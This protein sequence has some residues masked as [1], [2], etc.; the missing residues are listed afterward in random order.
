[1]EIKVTEE[2]RKKIRR[3]I[4]TK[5]HKTQKRFAKE[6]LDITPFYLSKLLHGKFTISPELSGKIVES[7]GLEFDE[8]FDYKDEDCG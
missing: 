2:G 4:F 6:D 5:L 1:M 3:V 8:I 7:T